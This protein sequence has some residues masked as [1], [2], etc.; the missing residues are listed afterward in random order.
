LHL[1][2]RVENRFTNV[3]FVRRHRGTA[4]QQHGMAE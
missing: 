1:G 4:R 3:S 2:G